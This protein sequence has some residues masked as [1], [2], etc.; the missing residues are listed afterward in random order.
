MACS[1]FE[2]LVVRSQEMVL[3]L[4]GCHYCG[5][6]LNFEDQTV[7][8]RF[9]REGGVLATILSAFDQDRIMKTSFEPLFVTLASL[10]NNLRTTV[11]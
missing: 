3:I 10:L 5:F 11:S 2:C 9:E 8:C 7:I 1:H 4:I 6:L